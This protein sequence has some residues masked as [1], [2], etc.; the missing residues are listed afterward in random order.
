[1]QPYV[2]AHDKP[3]NIDISKYSAPNGQYDKGSI[4][5]PDGFSYKIKS[6]TKPA[7]GS[8]EI[9][10]KS[11]ITYTPDTNDKSNTSGQIILTLEITKDV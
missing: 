9:T 4:V 6:V 10:D 5:I 3:F 8:I 2:I 11:N 1:M 7:H